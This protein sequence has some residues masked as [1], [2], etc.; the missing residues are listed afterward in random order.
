MR[1]T[2]ERNHDVDTSGALNELQKALAQ[3]DKVDALES[4]T[5]QAIDKAMELRGSDRTAKVVE[6]Q[7]RG[8]ALAAE[9]KALL[10][11]IA[12]LGRAGR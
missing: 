11:R 7:K 2:I 9:R 1:K 5:V 3:L 8:N 4:E 10:A 12:E 6:L